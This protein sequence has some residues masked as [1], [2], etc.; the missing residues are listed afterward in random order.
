ML[1]MFL[2]SAYWANQAKIFTGCLYTDKI[3]LFTFMKLT[4]WTQHILKSLNILHIKKNKQIL[5]IYSLIHKGQLV[6][7]MIPVF[8]I[9]SFKLHQDQYHELKQQDL[10]K[11]KLILC[12]M[13]QSNQSVPMP[14][15]FLNHLPCISLLKHQLKIINYLKLW[16]S[17]VV[18]NVVVLQSN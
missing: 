3:K 4:Q 2:S 12:P 1:L 13:D 7:I 16:L 6:F 14:N 11:L 18:P 5:I 15:K 9:L 17:K 10:T 8:I